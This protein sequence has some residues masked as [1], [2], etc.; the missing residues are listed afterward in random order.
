MKMMVVY[1]FSTSIL[2]VKKKNLPLMFIRKR[3]SVEFILISTAWYLKPIKLISF[4]LN[5]ASVCV[6]ILGNSIM[7]LIY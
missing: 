6:K 4:L 1:L 5:D 7:E 3:P 2:F